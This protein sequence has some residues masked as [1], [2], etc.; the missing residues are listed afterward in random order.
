[1]IQTSTVTGAGIAELAAA[2]VR[3][4]VPEEHEEPTLLT[5][6]VPF[7]ERQMRLL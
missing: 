2:I 3:R 7:T 4:L 6:P 5:G 1:V